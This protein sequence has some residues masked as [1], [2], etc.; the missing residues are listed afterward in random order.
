[1]VAAASPAAAAF[2][3]IYVFG[4]SLSA[5][6][7]T[8]NPAPGTPDYY[9]LRWSNGRVWVEVLAQR[10]GL[11]LSN[12]NND[13]Y[14][15]HNSSN[16]L[17][18]VKKFIP[19]ADVT[20]DLFV[21]WVCNA[22]MYDDWQNWQ[23]QP[24]SISDWQTANN[25]SVNNHYQVITNLYAKGVRTLILPNAVD[26][27]KIP[28]INVSGSYTNI[29]RAGCIDFNNKF[30]N[31]LNQALAACPGLTIYSPDY[32]TLLNNVL[33]NAAYYGLTNAL[34][35][36]LSIDALSSIPSVNL[37]NGIAPNY[38]FWDT[39]DPSARLHAVVA[40]VCQ[41]I[42]SPA[43]VR[44][45]SSSAGTNQLNI[46]NY[47]AGLAGYVDAATTLAPGNWSPTLGINSTNTTQSVFVPASGPQ[48]F[49]RLRF[50]Y[51]WSWP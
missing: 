25:V 24:L 41:K 19:P 10:Q 11:V 49:Y 7:D 51:A 20:N 46:V 5:S 47:P 48:Q 2:S 3:S 14:Y 13:S 29:V 50:P 35:N 23:N 44:S 38:I 36:G 22:D 32:F 27:S 6:H 8:V 15:D 16:T 33:T 4:D 40:D 45:I 39:Q 9:G 30:A 34:K 18:D 26:V 17:A 42:I 1:M 43:Q 12:A 28:A 37:S 21:V 31:T